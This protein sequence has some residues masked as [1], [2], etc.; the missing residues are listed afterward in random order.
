MKECF[1]VNL[2]EQLFKFL[3]THLAT[4][5]NDQSQRLRWGQAVWRM[6]SAMPLLVSNDLLR[7]LRRQAQWH[8]Q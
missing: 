2:N 8:P 1:H 5:Y 7:S 6:H 3:P 4:Q